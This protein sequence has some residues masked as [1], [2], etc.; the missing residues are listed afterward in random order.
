MKCRILKKCFLSLLK[1]AK[2][3][4]CKKYTCE[5]SCE[6]IYLRKKANK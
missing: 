6:E 3:L 4:S 1:Y 5:L 2:L